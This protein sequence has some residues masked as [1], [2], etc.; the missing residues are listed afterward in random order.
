MNSLNTNKFNSSVTKII[1]L[2]IT[3]KRDITGD[4]SVDSGTRYTATFAFQDVSGLYVD[5]VAYTLVSGTP[6]A[7]QYSFNDTTKE[8]KVELGA[9]LS[10]QRIVVHYDLFYTNQSARFIGIDPTLPD[11]DIREWMPYLLESPSLFSS[12]ED[13]FNGY[14]VTSISSIGVI[15]VDQELYDHLGANDSF[16]NAKVTVWVAID[17]IENI[18][19]SYVGYAS[20]TVE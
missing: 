6:T 13:V 19:K 8:I 20:W 16:Y 14:Y 11:T 9:A 7:N 15:N 1:L 10:T 17:S 4:L 2:K 18:H 12:I 3:P 5:G